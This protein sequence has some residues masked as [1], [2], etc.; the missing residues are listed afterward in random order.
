MSLLHAALRSVRRLL[1]AAV[2]AAGLWPA[3]GASAQ[4][5]ELAGFT[6]AMQRE[7][8]NRDLVIFADALE[9][10]QVQRDILDNLFDDYKR[11][12]ED[13][14]RQMQ[15]QLQDMKEQLQQSADQKQILSMIFVPFEDWA[16]ARAKLGDEF[17]RSVKTILNQQQQQV[18]PSFERRLLREKTLSKGVL[19]GESVNLLLIIDQLDL[20]TPVQED[21]QPVLDE[22]EITLDRALRQRNEMVRRSQAR[23]IRALQEQDPDESLK[24]VDEQLRERERVRDVNDLFI[25][26][27]A[28][29]LP[30]TYGADFYGRAME[31]AYPQAY[32]PTAGERMYKSAM[33]LEEIDPATRENVSALLEAFRAELQV[34]ADD[35]VET[36][37]RHEPKQKRYRVELYAARMKGTEP[38]GRTPDPVLT[39]MRDRE[40]LD[41]R[42]ISILQGL[43]SGDQFASLPGA[44]RWLQRHERNRVR[45]AADER[46]RQYEN[47]KGGPSGS[48]RD[49]RQER[50]DRSTGLGG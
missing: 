42:F 25:Q 12:F 34:F 10:D 41:E 33:E 32:R 36:I 23:M 49:V 45:E 24:L 29:S 30:A 7:Y 17:V 11:D 39:K 50:K 38:S 28:A 20:P 26:R 14:L 19:S 15:Q 44:E 3:S 1:P 46:Y 13:G 16:E 21:V 8:L 48:K 5:G 37:R 35:V 2:L 31:Q 43:L 27:I 6:E 18:W 4:I 40:Q 47:A 22:Y 9:L